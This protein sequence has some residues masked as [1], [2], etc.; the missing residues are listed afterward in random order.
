MLCKIL[1]LKTLY[2]QGESAFFLVSFSPKVSVKR[3]RP[4]VKKGL[5][6]RDAERGCLTNRLAAKD[7]N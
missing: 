4:W 1:I 3:G 7:E 5:R 2:E 6:R